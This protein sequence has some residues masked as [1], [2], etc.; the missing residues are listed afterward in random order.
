MKNKILFALQLVLVLLLS[1]AFSLAIDKVCID[2]Q[3]LQINTTYYIDTDTNSTAINV[4]KVVP[5]P[6]GC[7]NSDCKTASIL[8]VPLF[9]IFLGLSIILMIIGYRWFL[10]P[11][12]I[13]G[14]MFLILIGV[15]LITQGVVVESIL[16]KNTL[17]QGIGYSFIALSIYIIASVFI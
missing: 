13:I 9:S 4:S 11:L 8:N 15:V 7:E 2:N 17:T 5:C 10:D 1:P 16:Y 14:G 12:V 6:F 3:T